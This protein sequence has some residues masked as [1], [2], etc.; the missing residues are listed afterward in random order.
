MFNELLMKVQK[1]LNYYKDQLAFVSYEIKEARK[2]ELKQ[3][4]I[5][6]NRDQDSTSAVESEKKKKE[7]K[8]GYQVWAFDGEFW[9]DE[10]NTYEYSGKNLCTADE[11]NAGAKSEK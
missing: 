5:E 1:D 10:L 6:E 11:D 4:V 2:K 9:R 8:V 3:K 7:K